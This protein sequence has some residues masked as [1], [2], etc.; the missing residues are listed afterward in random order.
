[1]KQLVIAAFPQAAIKFCM[2]EGNRVTDEKTCWQEDA[3]LTLALFLNKYTNIEKITLVGPKAFTEKI[4][5]DFVNDKFTNLPE[6][7]LREK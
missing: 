3:N 7:E 2:V 5:T 4:R 1:M 6:I